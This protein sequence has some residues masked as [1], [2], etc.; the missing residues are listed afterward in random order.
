MDISAPSLMRL[1]RLTLQ[2]PQDA[3]RDLIAADPPVQARWLALLL[4]V[5]LSVLLGQ[6]SV[7]IMGASSLGLPSGLALSALLQG[8]MLVLTVVLVQQIGRAFGG[9]AQVQDTAL[10]MIWLQ[11]LMVVLQVLQIVLLLVLPPFAGLLG[12][13]GFVLFLWVLTNF[14]AHLHGFTSLGKVFGAIVATFFALGFALSL[15]MMFLG[16]V[17]PGM[18]NV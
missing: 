7:L 13:V 3:A 5:V 2:N 1:V 11:F 15:V 17:P 14:V 12:I 4:V 6:V 9:S 8:G 16:I 18:E 10:L